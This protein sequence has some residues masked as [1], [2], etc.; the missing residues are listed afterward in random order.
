YT[1]A[2]FDGQDDAILIGGQNETLTLANSSFTLSAWAKRAAAGQGHMILSQGSATT[3][4]GLQFGFRPTNK[5]TCG[6][7]N[8]DLDTSATYADTQWHHWVCT[9]D[10]AS[11]RRTLYRDGVQVAQNT[12]SVHYSGFGITYIGQR[13]DGAWRFKGTI[14][15]VG[16]WNSALSADQVRTLYEKVKVADE[17]VLTCQLPAAAGNQLTMH[18]LV[19]RQ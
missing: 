12:A 2:T 8:N 4:K 13:L 10:A 9:Y 3:N 5:F 15:E 7:W 18:D 11:K 14:D 1:A 19:L 17:T 6:F 16:I